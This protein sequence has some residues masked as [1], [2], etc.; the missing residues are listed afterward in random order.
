MS[1]LED[2]PPLEIELPDR[3]EF[4]AGL[5]CGIHF[6]ELFNEFG[7]SGP[8]TDSLTELVSEIGD[9]AEFVRWYSSSSPT[10]SI[11]KEEAT[12]LSNGDEIALENILQGYAP[13]HELPNEF[14]EQLRNRD[15]F[16]LGQTV[17]D[18]EALHRRQAVER[19]EWLRAHGKPVADGKSE[20]VS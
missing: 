20:A 8:L 11:C 2:G 14:W 4:W 19:V 10:Y 7:H 15:A 1:N 13:L 3:S 18:V 6:R 17:K 9:Q 16:R 12:W 5:D